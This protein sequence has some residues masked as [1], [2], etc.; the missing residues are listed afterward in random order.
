M[1]HTFPTVQRFPATND[2]AAMWVD[3]FFRAQRK[4]G[5]W[6]EYR[7][8]VLLLEWVTENAPVIEAGLRADS[9]RPVIEVIVKD[10][11][12]RMDALGV[13]PGPTGQEEFRQVL[14]LIGAFIRFLLE[15]RRAFRWLTY[16][17][18]R[19]KN[20]RYFKTSSFY[21]PV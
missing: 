14:Q 11:E 3:E 21:S 18:R 1:I 4:F 7:N 8:V 13:V 9:D 16:G 6:R 5:K 19:I 12:A 2:S 15:G 17:T 20:A 10:L